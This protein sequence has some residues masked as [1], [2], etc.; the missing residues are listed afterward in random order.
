MAVRLTV[1][2]FHALSGEFW[3][4]VYWLNQPTPD[5]AL[6]HANDIVLAERNVTLPEV[7]FTKIR[8]DDG[9]EN[10]EEWTTVVFNVPGLLTG[11]VGDPLPLFVVARVDF[12]VAGGGRP[13]RKYLRGVLTE[14]TMSFAAIASGLITALQAYA[15][16][17][18]ATSACDVDGQDIVSGAPHLQP[19]MRQLR[20]GSKKN[21][22]L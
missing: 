15:N 9:I 19:A 6:T 20:R 14:G 7:T 11:Q 22:I 16:A 3:T 21:N 17:V 12:S 8:I 13:S 4:N 10:T 2:K 1:E 5:D 18:A